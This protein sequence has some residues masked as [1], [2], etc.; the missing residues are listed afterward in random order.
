MKNNGHNNI[1]WK[2]KVV[3]RQKGSLTL[4]ILL[5]FAILIFAI[6]SVI[7]IRFGNQY[8][9]TDPQSGNQ[10]IY[11]DSQTNNEALYKAGKILEEARALS[12]QNYLSVVTTSSTEILGGLP[13]LK[14]LT[15]AD[16][17]QCKKQATSTISWLSSGRPQKIE[18]TTFFTD[19]AGALALGGDCET[20]PP[21]GDWQTIA[22][23]SGGNGSV[24]GTGVDAHDYISYVSAN[25]TSAVKPDLLIYKFNPIT[26]TLDPTD[27][28]FDFTSGFNSIDVVGNYAYVANNESTYQLQVVDVSNINSPMIVASSSLETH[29]VTTTGSDPEGQVIY[30]YNNKLYLGLHNTSGPEFHVFCVAPDPSFPS[31]ATSSP[32]NPIWMGSREMNHNI[33]SI[34]VRG[35]YAYLSMTTSDSDDKELAVLDVSNPGNIKPP[36]VFGAPEPWGFN[37]NGDNSGLSLFLIGNKVYL[38]MG[39]GTSTEPNLI[40]IDVSSSTSPTSCINC[41]KNVATE[42]INGIRVVGNFAFLS[43]NKNFNVFNISNSSNITLIKSIVLP[44]DG[45]GIDFDNNLVYIPIIK[46]GPVQLEIYYPGP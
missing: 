17:T 12:R 27:R 36:F 9:M 19:I 18:L 25:S 20:D 7:G 34:N 5:A 11:I 3:L 41:S 35:K 4:E 6:T 2:S 45:A 37:A 39:H 44:K 21:S 23:V 8:T 26:K 1:M 29:G 33:N 28:E 46:Q 10:S 15:V 13:Y 40:V 22:S 42:N 43:T 32:T 31:C 30:F 38:G 24:N 14:T 16:L